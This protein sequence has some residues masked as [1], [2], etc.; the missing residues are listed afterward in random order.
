MKNTIKKVSFILAIAVPI[1]VAIFYITVAPLETMAAPISVL[2]FGSAGSGNGQLDA[3]GPTDVA[4]DG[5]GNIYVV[6]QGNHR[7]QKFD[8]AG[9]YVSKFGTS[10]TGNGQ[11]NAPTAIDFDSS[12]NIFVLDSGN[13]RVQKF[14]SSGTYVSQFGTSGSGNGQFSNPLDLTIDS[15]DNVYV[16][17]TYNSRVQKFDSSGAY[18]LQFG[19]SGAST[20]QFSNPI[21]IAD[22]SSGNVYVVDSNNGR[23]QKFNSSGTYVSHFSTSLPIGYG[24]A[25]DSSGNIYVSCIFTDVVKKFDSSG[26]Y[27]SQFGSSGTSSGA[28]DEPWGI[29]TGSAGS[30]FVADNNNVRIQ[31]FVDTAPT[32]TAPASSAV[33]SVGSA[34]TGTCV[35]GSTVTALVDSV[36]ISPTASCTSSAYSITPGT[37]LSVGAHTVVVRQADAGGNVSASSSSISFSVSAFTNVDCTDSADLTALGGGVTPIPQAECEFLGSFYTLTS[38]SGWTDDTNWNTVS[39]IDDWYGITRTG[40]HVTAIILPNNH[41]V[42]T[43]PATISNLTALTQFQVNTN[44]LSGSIPSLSSNTL[45]TDVYLSSNQFTGSIP[46]LSALTALVNFQAY[47]NSL[48]GSIPSLSSNTNLADFSVS[49]NDLTGTIPDISANTA[50]TSFN[51]SGNELTGTIPDISGNTTLINFMIGSNNLT[52][53]IPSIASNTNLAL[54]GISQNQLTGSLPSV[55]TNTSLHYFDARYNKLTGDIPDFTGIPI[56]SG[57]LGENGLSTSSSAKNTAADVAFSVDWS[58]TQ[59]VAPT[60]ITATQSG[61]DIIVT[62]DPIEYTSVGS[63]KVYYG[64]TLG[65]PYSTLAGTV[66]RNTGTSL[67][68]SGLTANTNYYFIVQAYT[69]ANGNQ[70]NIITADSAEVSGIVVVSGGS[71]SGGGGSSSGYV[72]HRYPSSSDSKPISFSIL[73]TPTI[74]NSV[75]Q[76]KWSNIVNASTM[77][78]SLNP[79]F[80][81]VAN[82]PYTSDYNFTLPSKSGTYSIYGKLTSTTNDSV[83][84]GP[85]TVNIPEVKVVPKLVPVVKKPLVPKVITKK[86]V[87]TKVKTTLTCGSLSKYLEPGRINNDKNEVKL[88]QNFLNKYEGEE[89]EVN[90]TYDLLTQEAVF[91]FQAVNNMKVDG[92]IGS[93][94][95]LPANKLLGCK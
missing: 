79:S 29:N 71:S 4:V 63:Y 26:T 16:S 44:T 19:T 35:T 34:I 3:G 42:G 32:I 84:I 83:Q 58:A 88:W 89:L 53:S 28:L 73:N 39:D 95:R 15:S 46:S 47:Y 86:P 37:P 20:G 81:G 66:A 80:A 27:V 11:F 24:I 55:S 91:R 61:T 92:V 7:I 62:W 69:P 38:G 52:G 50:L 82:V 74:T 13:N 21:G 70:E 64:T 65:G 23:V 45:L 40:T 8:S 87:V 54:F 90:G 41:L 25:I 85:L 36:A 6:D 31:K 9:A 17:D 18:V 76:L 22:D 72:S 14:D 51:V 57:G 48:S 59:T 33:V 78:F 75:A 77:S 1:C 43:L 56:T 12:G 49:N 93:T 67:T 68:V 60:G 30:I 94:T 2:Q 10:G 5:S